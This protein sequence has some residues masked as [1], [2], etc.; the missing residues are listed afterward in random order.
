MRTPIVLT[1]FAL[2][3]TTH[4][5][6]AAPPV[7][8]V[9]ADRPILV[10][11][12][13]DEE[14]W[15][16]APVIDGLG[17]KEPDQGSPARQRSEV[18][19]AF[20]DDALYVGARLYDSAPD[21]II[22]RLTRRDGNIT[23]DAFAVFLDPFH[24]RRTGYYFGVTAAGVQLDGT[25]MNDSWDD[26][27]WDAVWSS[28]VKRDAR[29]WTLE[30]RIPYS[31]MRFRGGEQMVW[32]VNFKR[33][34]PRYNEEDLLEYIYGMTAESRPNRLFDHLRSMNLLFL[35]C[36]YPDWLSRFFIR[37]LKA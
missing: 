30:L 22:A 11:G 15:K 23:S 31:Q 27:S 29:G 2:T 4:A 33:F 36:N 21:S 18:R 13:L 20:D 34:I 25:L 12:L 8:A 28:A 37:L 5:A 6:A 17:Q 1:L 14:V 7:H 3:L 26:D 19:L 32:G 24:D 10:D 9:R 35:G 16:A